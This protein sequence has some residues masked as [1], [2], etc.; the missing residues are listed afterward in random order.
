MIVLP[1]AGL[2]SR[3]LK[4]GYQLPKYMLPLGAGSMLQSVLEGFRSEFKRQEFLFICRNVAE[5][6][7]FIENQIAQMKDGP[8][9]YRIAVLEHETSGQADTVYQGLVASNVRD[10]ETL[11]IF[12]IDSQHN[13]FYYPTE[14]ELGKIDGYLEVFSGEG[15]HWSFARP[16]ENDRRPG[17]VAEIA[18]KRRISNLCSSGLYY[19]KT[20]AYYKSLFEASL[21]T[22]A[23]DAEGGERYI[24]PLLNAAIEKGDD[25]R[26]SEIQQSEITFTGTPDEYHAQLR[27]QG[28]RLA[29]CLTGQ[30]RG[31]AERMKEM[32]SVAS[33][34]GADV[35]VST[36]SS[37]GRKTFTG[38]TGVPQL[39]RI[40]GLDIALSMPRCFLQRMDN[41]FPETQKLLEATGKDV[42]IELSNIF[43]NA[44]LDVEQEGLL[45]LSICTQTADHNSLRMLYK[46]WRCNQMKR[47]RER[48]NGERYDLVARF[49]P[50]M[51]PN[52]FHFLETR[53]V[54]PSLQIGVSDAHKDFIDDKFWMGSSIQ[55]DFVTSLY[56]K[57]VQSYEI[58]W[59]NIHTE[60]SRH[61]QLATF[62]YEA[63]ASPVTYSIADNQDYY[64]TEKILQALSAELE[65]PHEGMLAT[66]ISP[67]AM[68][69][70]AALF[71][72]STRLTPQAIN[73]L[74]ER[75]ENLKGDAD[76]CLLRGIAVMGLR[77]APA[78]RLE[79]LETFRMLMLDLFDAED[80][81][82]GAKDFCIWLHQFTDSFSEN[83]CCDADEMGGWFSN[84]LSRLKTLNR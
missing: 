80:S 29:I 62:A 15:T 22:R 46:I 32:S 5:T 36:W 34:L 2:S 16:A 1:M 3:F 61:L 77:A 25:I 82:I 42:E 74:L 79:D 37:W 7:A 14:F 63:P 52:L 53:I 59:S 30:I 64:D 27:Q 44:V 72:T 40:L 26:F 21:E 49:R 12:N 54:A 41:L 84:I 70:M 39:K 8:R 11:T 33:T 69:L 55:D 47:A 17:A 6:E 78:V 81:K 56:G 50:D 20:A 23:E 28:P 4:A 51:L 60:L 76:A 43:P 73:D 10:D 71:K 19:F 31:Q 58:P 38:A 35:F 48:Q 67:C 57:A 83:P 66:G 75:S 65:A 18:E 9:T 24:A 68:R 13:A 45:D